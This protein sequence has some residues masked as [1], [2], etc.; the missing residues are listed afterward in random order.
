[1]TPTAPKFFHTQWTGEWRD[2]RPGTRHLI[3]QPS[4]F[5]VCVSRDGKKREWHK[6]FLVCV[7]VRIFA[8]VCVQAKVSS[9]IGKEMSEDALVSANHG[10]LIGKYMDIIGH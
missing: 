5:L 8:L 3:G 9:S 4:L 1:M 10:T 2:L 7:Y 6:K